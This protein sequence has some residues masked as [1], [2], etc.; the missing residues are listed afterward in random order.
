[1]ALRKLI[2]RRLRV[3][4]RFPYDLLQPIHCRGVFP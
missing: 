3:N 1:V 4:A 2:S